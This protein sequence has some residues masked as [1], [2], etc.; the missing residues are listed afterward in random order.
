MATAVTRGKPVLLVGETGG[1]GKTTAVQ[2]LAERS[3]RR[4]R[5]LNLKQQ[6][7]SGDLLGGFDAVALMKHTL[8]SGVRKVGKNTAMLKLW[9]KVKD[10]LKTA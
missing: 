8:V 6:S 7:E 4:L 10:D 5:V 2:I 1:V 3:G 9:K